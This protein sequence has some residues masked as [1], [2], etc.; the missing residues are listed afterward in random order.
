M[1]P[2]WK[3]SNLF[4]FLPYTLMVKQKLLILINNS[5]CLIIPRP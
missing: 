5:F 2:F 3:G 1:L 4:N